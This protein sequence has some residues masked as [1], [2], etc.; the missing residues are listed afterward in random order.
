MKTA[1][2]LWSHGFIRTLSG[3]AIV[4]APTCALFFGLVST[5]GANTPSAA[6]Q[7]L[8]SVVVNA[9][10]ASG[11]T[12][13]TA[14]AGSMSCVECH[15]SEIAALKVSK[16]NSSITLITSHPK[17]AEFAKAANVALEDVLQDSICSSCHATQQDT[18]KGVHA[19]GSVSCESCHGGASGKPEWLKLHGDKK[20]GINAAVRAACGKA[21]MIRA[22]NIYRIT[23]NCVGCHVVSNQAL[24]N[25]GHPVSTQKWKFELVGGSSGEVRHNFQVDQKVNGEAP[26]AWLKHAKGASEENRQRMKYL[27]GML[28][29]LEVTLG[30]LKTVP[31]AA[32]K[33]D[34]AKGH[35]KRLKAVAKKLKEAVKELEDTTP[36]EL[37]AAQE[38]IDDIGRISSL[39]FKSQDGAEIA[40]PKIAAAASALAENNDGSK[41]GKLDSVVKKRAKPRGDAYTP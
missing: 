37:A 5:E 14:V 11:K 25:A 24:V 4:A 23:K 41:L 1:T 31:K 38:A 35:A 26:T 39:N 20:K 2:R 9:D 13:P 10:P 40:E 7:A 33:S 17:I 32:G 36:A 29:D 3:L 27:I 21:G 8:S 15:K 6:V 22:S 28:V 30:A 18:G 12:D 19:I 34:F 16:H